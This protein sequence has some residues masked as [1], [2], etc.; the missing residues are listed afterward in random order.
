MLVTGAQLRAAR[1]L[2]RIGQDQLAALAEI[3]PATVA[4]L[5][6]ADGPLNARAETLRRLQ[7]ALERAGVDFLPGGAVRLRSQ[8]TD[9]TEE[10]N[11]AAVEAHPS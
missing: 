7:R 4:R 8:A 5:E 6:G 1:A 10:A 2:T 9:N 11:N 3:A